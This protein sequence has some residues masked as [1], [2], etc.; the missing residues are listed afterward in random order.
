MF[1]RLNVRIPGEEF[2]SLDPERDAILVDLKTNHIIQSIEGGTTEEP[3][4]DYINF[5]DFS[6]EEF[7]E[8]IN[9]LLKS[10]ILNND[11]IASLKEYCSR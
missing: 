7:K 3:P 4:K 10:G 2:I 8:V 9:K 5:R 6:D 1:L 11:M